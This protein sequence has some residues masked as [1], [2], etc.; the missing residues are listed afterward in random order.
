MKGSTLNTDLLTIIITKLRLAQKFRNDDSGAHIP[1]Q[2]RLCLKIMKPI[3]VM[4]QMQKDLW[5]SARL[6]PKS[7]M[8][9]KIRPHSD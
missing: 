8:A 6:Y 1:D 4:I 3:P 5:G 2:M 9:T 7:C